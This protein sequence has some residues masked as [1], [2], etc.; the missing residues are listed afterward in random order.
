M[1]IEFVKL[2]PTQNMTILVK[3]PIERKDQLDIG[4]KLLDYSSVYAEQTGFIETSQNPEAIGRLQMMAGEFCANAT[5][6]MAAYAAWKNGLETGN[7]MVIP[8]EVSGADDILKCDIKAVENGYICRVN[9]PLP[10]KTE[11]IDYYIGEN[12]YVL[13]TVF[14]TGIR[15]I[16][17]PIDDIGVDFRDI[18]D[19][20]ISQIGKQFDDEAFGIIVFD[21]KESRIYPLVVIKGASTIWERGCGS[22]SEA[23]GVYLAQRIKRNVTVKLHQPGGVIE[24][25]VKY[26]NGI[27]NVSISGFVKIV[28]EGT[29]YI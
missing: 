23:V 19:K 10:I 13:F 15:H 21:E 7:S 27:K 24:T 1:K 20:N 16:I 12:K 11:D 29:A 4:T 25:Q 2:S 26:D 3:T 9:M 22:G 28:A 17:I 18:L 8:L 14:L 6:S 5:M